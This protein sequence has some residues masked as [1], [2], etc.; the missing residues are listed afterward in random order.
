[1]ALLANHGVLVVAPNV[2]LGYLRA[3]VLEWRCRMAWHVEL[4]G[5]GIPIK[6][7]VIDQIGGRFDNEPVPGLLHGMVRREIRLD[8]EVL[9]EAVPYSSG[10]SA[11]L[12]E[13]PPVQRTG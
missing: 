3:M 12:R 10:R 4:G 6:P 13:L 1:M 5:K 2:E 7:E 11:A 8:P 9:K